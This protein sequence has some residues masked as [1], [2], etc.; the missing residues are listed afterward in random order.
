MWFKRLQEA[1]RGVRGVLGAETL[2]SIPVGMET[3]RVGG[4]DTGF[5]YNSNREERDT[6]YPH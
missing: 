1:L 3:V 4:L 2:Y 5:P 6:W